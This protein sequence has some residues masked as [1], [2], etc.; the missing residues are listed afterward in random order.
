[1]R[2]RRT[3]TAALVAAAFAGLGVAGAATAQAAPQPRISWQ[4][5]TNTGGYVTNLGPGSYVCQGGMYGGAPI[6]SM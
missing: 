6:T 4:Q 1:M 2:V 5:C 3:L